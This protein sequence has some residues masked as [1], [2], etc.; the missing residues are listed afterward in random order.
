MPPNF[1]TRLVAEKTLPLIAPVHRRRTRI[2][3]ARLYSFVA[4]DRIPLLRHNVSVPPPLRHHGFAIP[5]PQ[6]G[7]L[8]RPQLRVSELREHSTGQV[9][10]N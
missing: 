10:C 6:Q 4:R 9:F 5:H 8:H 2:Y 1:G 7:R 3:I